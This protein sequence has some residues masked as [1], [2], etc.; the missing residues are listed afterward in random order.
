MEGD[1]S[2]NVYFKHSNCVIVSSQAIIQA[3][4]DTASMQDD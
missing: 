1:T 3:K 2:G 4:I